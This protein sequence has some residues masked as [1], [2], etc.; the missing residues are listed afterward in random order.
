[1]SESSTPP[2]ES[3]DKQVS[4]KDAEKAEKLLNAK[5]R[6]CFIGNCIF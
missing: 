1:M 6:V 2:N 3:V 4:S 5:K